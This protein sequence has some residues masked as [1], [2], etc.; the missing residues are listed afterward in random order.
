MTER[1]VSTRRTRAGIG[2]RR[3]TLLAAGLFAAALLLAPLRPPAA[4]ADVL[5]L[6]SDVVFYNVNGRSYH[7]EECRFVG[8]HS[9]RVTVEE[10]R[11]RGLSACKVCKPPE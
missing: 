10:A 2:P 6:A 4:S 3:R 9:A 11:A 1:E 5:G 8:S 7:A